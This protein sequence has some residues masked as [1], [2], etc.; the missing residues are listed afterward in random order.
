MLFQ[1]DK[2]FPIQVRYSLCDAP[3]APPR[4]AGPFVAAAVRPGDPVDRSMA[5]VVVVRLFLCRLLPPCARSSVPSGRDRAAPPLRAGGATG[6]AGSVREGQWRRRF[7]FLLL[8]ALSTAAQG[9]ERLERLKLIS[10]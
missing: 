7:R 5:A 4:A 6:S 2:Q 8:R 9:L 10:T 1:Y 3:R